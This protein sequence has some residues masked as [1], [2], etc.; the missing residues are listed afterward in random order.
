MQ[1]PAMGTVS[2]PL[3]PPVAPSPQSTTSPQSPGAYSKS[4]QY[5]YPAGSAPAPGSGNRPSSG[6]PGAMPYG[7]MQPQAPRPVPVAASA[8]PAPAGPPTPTGPS[9]YQ[10]A[11]PMPRKRGVP[12]SAMRALIRILTTLVILVAV[13]FVGSIVYNTLT[14]PVTPS[15]TQSP[16]DSQPPN[17]NVS[18]PSV[19]EASATITW[20]TDEPATSQVDYGLTEDYGTT[21]TL[22]EELTTSHSVTL[23]GLEHNTKYY[24]NVISKDANGNG[25]SSKGSLTTAAQADTT[26]PVISE[27]NVSGITETSATVTWTTDE[28]ATTQVKYG[29]TEAYGTTM[30]RDEKLTKNHSV[31]LAGLEPDTTYYL[32]AVSKDASGNEATSDKTFNTATSIPVGYEEGDRA[33]DFTLEDINNNEVQLSDFRG[34]IVMVNFW[35]IFCGPCKEELPLIQAISDNW[36]AEDLKILAVNFK[37]GRA[38]VH[39]W[40]NNQE[41]E[42]TFTFLLDSSGEVDTLYNV[43]FY[44]TTFFIDAEG[45]IKKRK[46]GS[47]SSQAEIEAILDSLK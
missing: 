4:P 32:R 28:P 24:Y 15:P 37:E 35:G 30:P 21:K 1:Q 33:P 46:E 16:I 47:F 41:E 38:T 2:I 36:S 18:P 40:I 5:N 14:Q 43:S 34:K 10:A 42:Y 27:L 17:I 44:P 8:I 26:P 3:K 20:T 23:A 6:T 7:G 25:A 29:K 12:Q 19:T 39:D 11:A 9:P 22:D 13:F 45:I 31:T